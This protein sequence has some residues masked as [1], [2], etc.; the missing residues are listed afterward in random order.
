MEMIILPST[1]MKSTD[2]QEPKKRHLVTKKHLTIPL[3]SMAHVPLLTAEILGEPYVDENIKALGKDTKVAPTVVLVMDLDDNTE[4]LLVVNAIIASALGKA[5]YPITGRF[6]Q[7]RAGTI[8]EGK[9]YR[10]IDVTEMMLHDPNK[11]D[12]EE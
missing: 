8:R 10:D 1:K 12:N 4:K 3:V 9:A 6:F 7:F 2:D 11:H 5:G